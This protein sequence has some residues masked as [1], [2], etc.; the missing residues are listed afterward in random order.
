VPADVG[1]QAG[2]TLHAHKPVIAED[3]RAQTRLAGPALLTTHGVISGM[4]VVIEG[5][6]RR[7]YGVLGVHSARRRAF[8]EQDVNFVQVVANLLASALERENIEAEPRES[9]RFTQ[10]VA[11]AVPVW[12][13]FWSGLPGGSSTPTSRFQRRS[14]R[15][16]M[17]FAPRLRR[18]CK[19]SCTGGM[20]RNSPRY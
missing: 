4:S 14:V 17:I 20:R 8:T 2:F 5:A 1:S 10:R 12:C 11:D 15:R 9:R 13:T 16:R 18:A 7:P 6:G 3:L 19:T